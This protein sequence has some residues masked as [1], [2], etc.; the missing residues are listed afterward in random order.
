MLIAAGIG[1][2]LNPY[3]A[4]WLITRN[5]PASIAL[6]D[7]DRATISTSLAHFYG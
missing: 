1:L 5:S 7:M 6:M 3:S 2:P 4:D